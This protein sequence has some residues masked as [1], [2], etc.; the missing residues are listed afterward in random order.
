MTVGCV[1]QSVLIA[2]S[3]VRN[4]AVVPLSGLHGDSGVHMVF[5]STQRMPMKNA[6]R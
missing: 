3:T 5:I 1:D 2:T 4:R 6:E